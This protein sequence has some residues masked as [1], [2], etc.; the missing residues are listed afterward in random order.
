MAK[1]ILQYPYP[2]MASPSVRTGATI[3]PKADH[4][5]IKHIGEEL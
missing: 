2:Y 4:F 3:N 5:D 1:G